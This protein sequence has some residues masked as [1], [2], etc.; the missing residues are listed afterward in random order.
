MEVV[1]G[2]VVG[3]YGIKGWVKLR[4][5]T[6]PPENLLQYRPWHLVKGEMAAEHAAIEARVH[7]KG[8]IAKLAGVDDRDAAAAWVGAEIFVER[9]ALGPPETGRFFWADLLGL[10]VETADGRLLGQVDSLLETGANDVLVVQGDK[11]RLIPFV[12]D[13]VISRVDLPAG[14]IVADWDPEF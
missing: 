14:L 5:F 9:R 11:R 12:M 3:I 7:G 8:L 1:V 10:R 6:A 4:S 2:Q 13:D